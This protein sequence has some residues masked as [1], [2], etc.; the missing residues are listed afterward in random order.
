[1]RYH[2][3]GETP[4]KRRQRRWPVDCSDPC[5]SPRP[6]VTIV[7]PLSVSPVKPWHRTG[8]LVVLM[9]AAIATVALLTYQDVKRRY[10]ESLQEYARA[11]ETLA[12]SLAADLSARIALSYAR[13]PSSAQP[14]SS[15]SLPLHELSHGL[16]QIEQPGSL[17][18]FVLRPGS[19]MFHSPDGQAFASELMLQAVRQGI[20]TLRLPREEAGRLRLPRRAA[21]VGLASLTTDAQEVFWVAAVATVYRAR[22]RE[23]AAGWRMVLAVL[24]AAGAML[25]LGGAAL[26]GQKRELRAQHSLL[27]EDA[28]R[29]RDSELERASRAATIGTL[30]MGITHE[31]STPLGIITARAEQL[32]SKVTKDERNLRSVRVILEQAE[33]MSQIIC[34]LL[35]LA[36]GQHVAAKALTPQAVMNGAVSLVEHRFSEAGVPLRILRPQTDELLRGDQRLLE[37]A[38]VNLLLNACDACTAEPT[39]ACYVELALRIAEGKVI[40]QVLD[41]GAGISQEAAARAMEPFFTTKPAGQGSGLGLAIAHEIVKSHRGTLLIASRAEGGTCAEISLPL[42]PKEEHAA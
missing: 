38:L 37:H 35:G 16:A 11:Q 4:Y 20:S 32:Q 22:D 40:F 6:G 15:A 30:A 1:M 29:R 5:K 7:S 8:I 12:R 34:G 19:T 36:R 41:T 27:V 25:L 26:W 33:R 9:V 24:V 10:A 42:L 2:L 3:R 17:A 18:V 13:R 28:R 23:D 39:G 14:T 21:L 31:L